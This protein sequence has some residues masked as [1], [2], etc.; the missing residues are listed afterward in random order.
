MRLSKRKK[1]TLGPIIAYMWAIWTLWSSNF[2]LL[3]RRVITVIYF[4]NSRGND[5][6]DDL[7]EGNI[8]ERKAHE[9]GNCIMVIFPLPISPGNPSYNSEMT[10]KFT[11]Y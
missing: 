6:S 5:F 7:L 3:T 11:D 1:G 9:K 10:L 4:L 8:R 2:S